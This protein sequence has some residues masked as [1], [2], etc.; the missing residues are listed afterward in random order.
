MSDL[1]LDAYEHVL[2][3]RAMVQARVIVLQG[4]VNPD[5]LDLSEIRRAGRVVKHLTMTLD[6]IL[7]WFG[8]AATQGTL[9]R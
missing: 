9:P 2:T 4:K 1:Y 3:A 5:D 8:D 7:Y 6:E